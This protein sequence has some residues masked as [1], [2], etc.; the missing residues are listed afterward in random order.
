M[1]L[2]EKNVLN[3]LYSLKKSNN[4]QAELKKI[5]FIISNSNNNIS[6]AGCLISFVEIFH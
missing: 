6:K 2:K 4:E 3:V 5:R 1:L